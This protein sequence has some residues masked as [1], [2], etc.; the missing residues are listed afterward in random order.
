MLAQFKVSVEDVPLYQDHWGN[1][2]QQVRE[3]IVSQDEETHGEIPEPS[4]LCG[5]VPVNKAR[6]RVGCEVLHVGAKRSLK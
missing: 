4:H 6:G 5:G 2:I 3:R 1:Y